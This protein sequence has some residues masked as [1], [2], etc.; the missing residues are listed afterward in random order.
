MLADTASVRWDAALFASCYKQGWLFLIL[1]RGRFLR[2]GGVLPWHPGLHK[3][4]DLAPTLK[5]A[6]LCSAALRKGKSKSLVMDLLFAPGL[7][8][9]VS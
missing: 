6:S 3:P 9:S 5:L 8:T 4:G 7:G 2:L 1:L